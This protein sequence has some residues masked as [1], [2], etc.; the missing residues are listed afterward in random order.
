MLTPNL[1]KMPL[2]TTNIFHTLFLSPK[3]FGNVL[4]YYTSSTTPFE[5]FFLAFPHYLTKASGYYTMKSVED[6]GSNY[7]ESKH[8]WR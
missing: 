2:L 8:T 3:F 4:S 5:L 7:Y 1:G 6:G